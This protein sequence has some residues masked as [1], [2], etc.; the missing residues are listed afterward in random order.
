MNPIKT[1]TLENFQSHQ[2]TTIE[3][4]QAGKL[5]VIVGPSDT[6]KTVIVRALRWLLY[7]IPQ[8]T[9]FIRVGCSFARVTAEFESGHTVI[10]ER[11][12]SKNQ[13]KI[14]TPWAEG[15]E[16]YEGFGNHVPIEVQEITGVTPVKIGDDVINLNLSEQLDGP[17]LGTKQ[18]SDPARAKVFGKMAGTEE[19]DLAGKDL[20]TDLYR[21]NQEEKR[22]KTEI[23]LLAEQVKAFDYLP[24]MERKIERLRVLCELVKKAQER[25][26]KLEGLIHDIHQAEGQVAKQRLLVYRLRN[27]DE[28]EAFLNTAKDIAAQRQTLIT[29]EVQFRGVREAIERAADTLRRLETLSVAEGCCSTARDSLE[30]RSKLFKAAAEYCD[31]DQEV[32]HAHRVIC[33][34]RN[35]KLADDTARAAENRAI[36][37]ELLDELRHRHF[38]TESEIVR[39][40]TR[41]KYYKGLAEAAGIVAEGET[42]KARRDLLHVAR[43]HNA[44]LDTMIAV[45]KDDLKRL[46]GVEE[47]A[48]LRNKLVDFHSRWFALKSLSMGFSEKDLLVIGTE[49][50][51]HAQQITMETIE[52]DYRNTLAEAGIC[53]L[54]G[55]ELDP[56]NINLKEVV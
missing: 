50:R 42:L 15:P 4:A 44:S 41:V 54:C 32:C 43:G 12:K 28:A 53:P 55:T 5:T 8:G 16:V 1:L 49:K 47:A 25:K 34:W 14:I 36:R 17:F 52:E 35:V 22:V 3:P 30:K 6:G 29:L 10:R 18:L 51:I 46:A 33:F 21:R 11:T 31:V 13:Y 27:L 2:K 39:F 7:N 48:E 56:K 20:G 19:I 37:K 26:A 45:K 24:A 40:Q 23:D 9:D 38:L